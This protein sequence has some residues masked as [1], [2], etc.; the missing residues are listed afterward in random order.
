M[1]PAAAAAA[2]A[3]A[4]SSGGVSFTSAARLDQDEV[5]HHPIEVFQD[6]PVAVGR[7]HVL[8]QG[9]E[10]TGPAPQVE[11]M[12]LV[13]IAVD[14]VEGDPRTADLLRPLAVGEARH[15]L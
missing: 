8:A 9:V 15:H 13:G 3:P 6:S 5:A 7:R 4:M 12:P 2:A 1:P 14:G 11:E 10:G